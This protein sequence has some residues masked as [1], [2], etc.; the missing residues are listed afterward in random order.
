MEWR[1]GC[2]LQAEEPALGCMR[3][4]LIQSQSVSLGKSW[5]LILLVD[6]VLHP[7]DDKE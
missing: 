7:R 3:S 1:Q 4:T 5:V 2:L 6:Q